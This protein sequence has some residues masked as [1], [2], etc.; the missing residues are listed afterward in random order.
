MAIL[1]LLVCGLCEP[2]IDADL[3]YSKVIID[4]MGKRVPELDWRV[5]DV[6][7]LRENASELG[8]AGSWDVIID[9]GS[10]SKARANIGT[11]DAL[12]AENGS[13]WSPSEQVL[14]NVAREVDG[15]I[16]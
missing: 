12:M 5:M 14:D 6:R 16:Q 8:G 1:T 11:M 15:V 2:H 13:V 9:K 10:C 3:D 4:K 7:E